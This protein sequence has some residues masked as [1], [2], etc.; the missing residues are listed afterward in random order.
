MYTA[1]YALEV[2]REMNALNIAISPEH[3]REEVARCVGIWETEGYTRDE[4]F[5]DNLFTEECR[6][7]THEPAVFTK[8]A[9][10]DSLY[11][12]YILKGH[13][14]VIV[15]ALCQLGNSLDKELE[16]GEEGA[17][18]RIVVAIN[19]ELKAKKLRKR[20]Y[21]SFATKYCSFHNFSGYSLFDTH[22]RTTL[23]DILKLSPSDFGGKE[24]VRQLESYPKL[25]EAIGRLI[26]DN[27]LKKFGRRGVDH[28][29]WIRG[30]EEAAK[31]RRERAAE[32]KA[33]KA[34][35]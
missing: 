3:L 24:K 30:R 20:N 1:R 14:G 11:A 27:G 22:A 12:T 32:R 26:T 35:S 2:P 28:Y 34:N 8:V 6:G 17:V 4:G 5:L 16:H 29:L 10:L 9:A 7:N 25:H 33:A 13:H 21:Y 15:D 18:G 23:E 31:R 19:N